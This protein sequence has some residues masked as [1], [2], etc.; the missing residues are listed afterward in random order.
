LDLTIARLG[1]HADY[2][3][4]AAPAISRKRRIAAGCVFSVFLACG[5]VSTP[6]IAQNFSPEMGPSISPM[7]FSSGPLY[8]IL[9]RACPDARIESTELDA[10]RVIESKLAVAAALRAAAQRAAESDTVYGKPGADGVYR[11]AN[12]PREVA[13]V[14]RQTLGPSSLV[15][16]GVDALAFLTDTVESTAQVPLDGLNE[17]TDI[18]VDQAHRAGLKNFPV[19]R[20]RSR[21]END[22]AGV[23]LSARW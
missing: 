2:V 20:F 4:E 23:T 6:A 15:T 8:P 17:F 12:T 13:T 11:F 18:L 14:F 10:V 1:G 16:R 19:F 22:R 5:A 21:I 7:A 9:M 3:G